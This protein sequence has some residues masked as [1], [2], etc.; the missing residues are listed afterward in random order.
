MGGGIYIFIYQSAYIDIYDV[1]IGFIKSR[2]VS[3]CG[4]G[5]GLPWRVAQAS[6]SF[7]NTYRLSHIPTRLA[8]TGNLTSLDIFILK[9]SI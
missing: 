8:L 7:L 2:P 4:A 6:D 1:G 9:Q 5:G 3:V